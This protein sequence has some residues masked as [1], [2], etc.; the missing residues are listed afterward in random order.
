MGAGQE[1]KGGGERDGGGRVEKG[2]AAVST[3]TSGHF[4]TWQCFPMA[5]RRR[6]VYTD[7]PEADSGGGATVGPHCSHSD[8]RTH[9]TRARAHTH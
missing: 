6:C 4:K 3:S 8:T 9:L 1:G 7:G 5:A 2:R